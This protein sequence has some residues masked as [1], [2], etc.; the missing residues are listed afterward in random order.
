MR[1]ESAVVNAVPSNDGGIFGGPQEEAPMTAAVLMLLAAI[2]QPSAAQKPLSGNPCSGRELVGTWQL[3]ES[4]GQPVKSDGRTAYKHVTP[5]HFFVL[6]VDSAGLAEYAH[7]GPYTLSGGTYVESIKQ[8]V[9]PTFEALRGLKGEFQCS[10]D[11][12]RWHI[13]GKV[14]GAAGE[15]NIDETW[16]R[17]TGDKQ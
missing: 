7:G 13:V 11:G 1:P 5:T 17:V 12:D 16:R 4:Q 3:I 15:G 9:G 8:G 10:M 14:A 6:N 2:Q